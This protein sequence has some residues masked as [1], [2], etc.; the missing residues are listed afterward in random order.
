MLIQS[1]IHDSETIRMP[2]ALFSPDDAR[3]SPAALDF[4]RAPEGCALRDALAA[5]P[6]ASEPSV[7]EIAALRKKF[8]AEALHAGLVLTA[9]Q[10]R[11]KKKFPGIPFVWATP[12]SLEQ[13]TGEMV[14][15]HKAQRFAAGAG[16]RPE[17][18]FDLCAGVGGDALCLAEIAP[19]T[20]V[21]L[22]QVRMACLRFNVAERTPPVLHAIDAQAVDVRDM[23]PQMPAGALVHIDPSRRRSGPRGKQRLILYADSIPGPELIEAF[24]KT[25]AG[26]A[27][28]LSPAMDFAELPEAQG[29]LELISHHRSVVQAVLWRGALAAE[30]PSGTR[31][32]AVLG[33]SHPPVYFT[34]T[35][36]AVRLPP[37]PVFE[38]FFAP[39]S[40]SASASRPTECTFYELDGAITRARLAAPFARQ[41]RL[42]PLTTD[43]GYLFSDSPPQGA[44]NPAL[45]PFILRAVTRYSESRV[46]AMLN[47]LPP[48][49]AGAVELKSRGALHGIDTDHLQKIWSAA[50]P[51]ARTVLLFSYRGDI[52]AAAADRPPR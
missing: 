39:D 11:A 25:A 9:L 26:G 43:G 32:A 7:S 17:R 52:L 47:D 46:A 8:P 12:E 51:F 41:Q 36:E 5:L 16:G 49:A 3:I 1:P 18:I 33:D 45:T 28:K 22:S 13:A 10:P 30:F 14:G 6:D 50:S 20:A 2:E 23:L 29:H 27:I 44:A 21:D 48:S 31:T 15:R 34:A 4:L 38:A 24:F 35:P 42:D 37:V 19:V 40:A